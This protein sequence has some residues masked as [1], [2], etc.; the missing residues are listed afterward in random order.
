M[1]RSWHGP[2]CFRGSFEGRDLSPYWE[3]ELD[4]A[5]CAQLGGHRV[6][7]AAVDDAQG[8]RRDAQADPA[9]HAG[10]EEA[11]VLQV[12]LAAGLRL[13]VRVADVVSDQ[14]AL[15]SDLTDAGHDF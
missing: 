6:D 3:R 15:S 13:V 9:L 12:R 8:V 7:T 11:V 10:H 4:F 14:R 1:P 2:R 5:G